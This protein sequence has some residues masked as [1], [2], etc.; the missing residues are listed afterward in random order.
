[1][2]AFGNSFAVVLALA[3]SHLS[4]YWLCGGREMLKVEVVAEQT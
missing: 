2:E 1:M 4:R 3:A